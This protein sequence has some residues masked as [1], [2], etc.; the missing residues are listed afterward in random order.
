MNLSDIV[1]WATPLT[2]SPSHTFPTSHLAS[3]TSPPTFPPTSLLTYPT[4]LAHLLFYPAIPYTPYS[5]LPHVFPWSG[6]VGDIPSPLHIPQRCQGGSWGGG[7]G[8]G[9]STATP[10]PPEVAGGEVARGQE[11][12]FN[13][14]PS[15]DLA[16]FLQ[17]DYTEEELKSFAHRAA[18]KAT[19]G[20]EVAKMAAMDK[21]SGSVFDD[22]A[23][24]TNKQG[25]VEEGRNARSKSEER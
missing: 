14:P 18:S 5:P 11:V 19:P 21:A 25:K 2:P 15:P 17:V 22:S 12:L 13:P 7:G 3:H 4:F 16:P 8:G 10:Q 9:R 1:S 6:E 23:I 24:L 20:T